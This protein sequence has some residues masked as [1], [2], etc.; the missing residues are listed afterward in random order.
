MLDELVT[1]VTNILKE[2]TES[3]RSTL[4][5]GECEDFAD[6]CSASG[7]LRGVDDTLAVLIAEAKNLE[8]D[9]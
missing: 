6:Y 5:D 1:R 8:R 7:Y 3:R 2:Y 9:I 4:L